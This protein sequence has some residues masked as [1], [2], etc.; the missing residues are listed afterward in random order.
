VLTTG[1]GGAFGAGCGVGEAVLV[2]INW[3]HSSISIIGTRFWADDWDRYDF[4]AVSL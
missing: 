2:L 3:R 4:I 1:F